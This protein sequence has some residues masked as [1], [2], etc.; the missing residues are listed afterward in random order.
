VI[1][2]WEKY[3]TK[4]SSTNCFFGI[5]INNPLFSI[6]NFEGS[7]LGDT[8]SFSLTAT[9]GVFSIKNYKFDCDVETFI[10][11]LPNLKVCYERLKGSA[12]LKYRYEDP[13]IKF[14]FGSN[15]SVELLI[16]VTHYQ[17]GV[18]EVIL[19]MS[20]DQSYFKPFIEKIENVYVELQL[21]KP[22]HT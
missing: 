21:A 22:N 20:L 2:F 17:E 11:F 7:N 15:G 5:D 1:W 10:E 14:A 4:K 16:H 6:K 8:I 19:S 18:S 9:N 13:Y 3:M 12:M